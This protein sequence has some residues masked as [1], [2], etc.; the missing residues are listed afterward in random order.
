MGEPRT[1]ISPISNGAPGAVS[2]AQAA[3]SSL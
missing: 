2:S 1:T 3:F